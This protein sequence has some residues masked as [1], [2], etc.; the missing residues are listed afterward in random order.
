LLHRTKLNVAGLVLNGI[1]GG[2]ERSYY[3]PYGYGLAGQRERVLDN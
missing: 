3:H 1:D 2:Y